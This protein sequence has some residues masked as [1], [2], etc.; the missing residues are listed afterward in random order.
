MDIKTKEGKMGLSVEM[1]GA[2]L[3]FAN[4]MR[5]IMMSEIPTD[6]IEE[7]EIKENNSALQ[8]EILAHRLGL[9]PL[10]GIGKLTLKAEGPT[11]VKSSDLIA[12]SGVKI[13]NKGLPIVELLANQKI[14]LSTKTKTG[15]GKEHIKWK[16]AI[17]S[18][19]YKNEDKINLEIESCSGLT[20]KEILKKSLDIL[21][22]KAGSFSSEVSKYKI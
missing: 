2:S 19:D 10:K 6:A 14:N 5:R 21:K 9:I 11:T 22:D 8:D 13:T 4:A 12:D 18:Y 3:S 20:N 15:T 7:V 1:K 16:G 17:V